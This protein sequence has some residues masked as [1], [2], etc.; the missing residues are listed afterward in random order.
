M[1]SG[2]CGRQTAVAAACPLSGERSYDSHL[3][4][5]PKQPV[6]KG[7]FRR[8]GVALCRPGL[9]GQSRY[10]QYPQSCIRCFYASGTG[11]Q[12]ADRDVSTQP[13][14]RDGREEGGA[15]LRVAY[16]PY[17]GYNFEDGV[18]ISE[19]AAKKLTSEHM[20][21][22]DVTLDKGVITSPRKYLVQHPDTY[23]RTQLSRMDD[24][25]VI[26][27]GRKVVSG[28]PLALA[29]RPFQAKDRMSLQAIGRALS[30]RHTDVS[31]QWQSDHPG[32]VV[33]VHKDKDKTTVHVRT[34]E[35]MQV[36]DK[37]SGRHGNKG[38]VTKIVPDKQ[39]PHT[40]DG[41]HVAYN[42]NPPTSGAHSASI[43]TDIYYRQ[44][45]DE[46]LVHNLEH[47]HIWYSYRDADDEE[48][49]AILSELQ[50]QN[51]RFVVVT[52][53]PQN[54]SRIAA[55]AWGRLLILEEPDSEQLRAFSIRYANNAPENVAG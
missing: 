33:A 47:G 34:Q 6:E 7:T 49:I 10:S 16:L 19:S 22:P 23:S 51:P 54:D 46:A 32:E 52:H 12:R 48:T 27:V 21:K 39:M 24:D 43:K 4:A 26:R 36:G 40:A 20:H 38:I 9:L 11:R 3:S 1:D 50:S 29:M 25:G 31:L 55:A 18:V 42:S 41:A 14:G 15:N 30:G 13:N 2:S 5:G 35:P 37:L 17:K 44:F 28:D 45:D 8:T 53:R